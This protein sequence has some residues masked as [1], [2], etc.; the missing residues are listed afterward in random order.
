MTSGRLTSLSHDGLEFVVRD[1][2]P[3]DGDI[4]VLLHGFPQTGRAWDVVVAGLHEAGYRTV[5]PDLRGYSPGA[6]PRGRFAYRSSKIVGDVVAL[7]AATGGRPVHLIGHDWGALLAWSVAASRPDLIRTLTAVSVP[8]YAAF[9]LSALSSNQLLRSY[10]IVLFQL[11]VVPELLFRVFPHS[12]ANAL[13]RS[14]LDPAGIAQ[15][16]RD[17]VDA[18]ALTP[19]INW[20]RGLL[21]SSQRAMTR[22]VTVPTTFVWGDADTLLG[23]RGANL[24]RRFVTGPYTLTVLPGVGHWVPGQSPDALVRA[25]LTGARGSAQPVPE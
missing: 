24:T 19:G 21:A 18:G 6:R 15:V 4:V 12:F 20:Y 25:F 9:L 5:V 8:H 3:A 1:T 14:G 17:V 2:G 7:I 13:R 11:P 16:Q 23:R 10:Y 22:K